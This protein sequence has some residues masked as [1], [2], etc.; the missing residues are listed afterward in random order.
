MFTPSQVHRVEKCPVSETYPHIQRETEYSAAG[1][2]AHRFMARVRELRGAAAEAGQAR[3][4]ALREVEDPEHLAVLEA[5]PLDDPRMPSLDPAAFT[6]ELALAL[7]LATGAA[8]ILGKGLTREQARELA[9]PGEM[10]GIADLAAKAE[11]SGVVL[12]LKFGHGRVPRAAVNLQTD[13]YLLML[14][15]ALRL[16]DGGHQ[17]IVWVF[18][19]EPWV[20]VVER[21]PLELDDH[22]ERLRRLATQV[23]ELRARPPAE[24]PAPVEGPWCAYCPA[25]LSCPAKRA[26]LYALVH[27]PEGTIPAPTEGTLAPA[28]MGEGWKKLRRAKQV[29]ERVEAIFKELARIQPIQL[30][31]GEVLAE[32]VTEGVGLVGH[33]AARVLEEKLPIV[34]RAVAD[35]A[36]SEMT[37]ASL[38]RALKTHLMPT[39]PRLETK[40]GKSKPQPYAPVERDILKLLGEHG[41]TRVTQLRK[42]MEFTPKEQPLPALP[43][44]QR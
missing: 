44:G 16:E 26:L 20:D 17:G 31:D 18:D 36:R 37:K 28:A 5:L 35:A 27:D 41:A 15:R 6:A 32:R 30:G 19:D 40:G 29:L 23:E 2:A 43:E 13:T 7:N 22:F 11:Q 38:E 14:V 39:L 33:L 34:G 9:Q 21:D 3:E 24:R 4:I 8:R 1:T 25:F 10:V 12:D 42:V